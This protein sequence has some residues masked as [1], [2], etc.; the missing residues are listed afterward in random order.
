M[1]ISSVHVAALKHLHTSFSHVPDTL[2]KG[3]N[4][5]QIFQTSYQYPN[6]LEEIPISRAWLTILF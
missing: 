1:L 2:H 4:I 3:S 6:F 5:Y